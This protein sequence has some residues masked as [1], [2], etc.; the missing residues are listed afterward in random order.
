M[1]RDRKHRWGVSHKKLLAP[2]CRGD[3]ASRQ[4][5]G[6]SGRRGW[7][8]APAALCPCSWLKVDGSAKSISLLVSGEESV[9]LGST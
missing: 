7:E 3:P 2:V 5:A 9:F 1:H 6:K 4:A 8:G